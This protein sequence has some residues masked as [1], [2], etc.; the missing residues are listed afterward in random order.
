MPEDP[1]FCLMLWMSCI[2]EYYMVTI[3]RERGRERDG[4]ICVSFRCN[5]IFCWD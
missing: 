1:Y 3:S 5:F 4:T 2:D